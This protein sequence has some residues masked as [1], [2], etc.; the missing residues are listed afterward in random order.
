MPT[1]YRAA[2]SITNRPNSPWAPD[3]VWLDLMLPSPW[4]EQLLAAGTQHF[5]SNISMVRW[6]GHQPVSWHGN[7]STTLGLRWL[8]LKT[9]QR[10]K[11]GCFHWSANPVPESV[12]HQ[13]GLFVMRELQ[14]SVDSGRSGTVGQWDSWD[15]QLSATKHQCR[16]NP[17]QHCCF[18]TRVKM[19]SSGSFCVSV[20]ANGFI[21]LLQIT[22]DRN[23]LSLNISLSCSYRPP[24]HLHQRFSRFK[25]KEQRYKM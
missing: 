15:G 4:T 5:P 20:R 1:W 25:K 8:P 21:S 16:W 23:N 17:G 7:T 2:H 19:D 18:G 12:W 9:L 11:S 24:S 22:P 14:L 10:P 3:A 6:P 13:N